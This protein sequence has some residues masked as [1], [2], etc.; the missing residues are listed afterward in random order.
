MIYEGIPEANIPRFGVSP[1]DYI[2]LVSVSA[3][4]HRN[5]RLSQSLL[6]AVWH[7]RARADQRRAGDILRV[8]TCLASTPRSGARSLT[9]DTA[10]ARLSLSSATGCGS[11]DSAG[12]TCSASGVT[13]EPQPYT[14]VGVM[15]AS[16]QFPTR[17]AR[18]STASPRTSGC[19]W[20]SIRSNDRRVAC[21]TT[22]ASWAGCKRRRTPRAGRQPIPARW[23]RA[24]A[25]TIPRSCATR[26]SRWSSWP[27]AARR[28]VGP[29]AA[30]AAA[31]ARRGRAGLAGG[32]RE[33]RQLD[34]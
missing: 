24:S 11:G 31:P 4:V 16:F 1:P 29:G 33:R 12:A 14:I 34:V 19:H 3:V 28:A 30:A 9:D 2:D 13:L 7:G 23:P 10:R 8:P 22:T 20:S 18:S 32:V 6:R 17:V 25:P 26:R 15:P 27:S 21:S 5:R